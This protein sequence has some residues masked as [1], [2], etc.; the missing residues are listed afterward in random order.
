MLDDDDVRRVAL[1]FP[2]TTEKER[3]SHPTFDVA[4]KM[5]VTVP[6]DQTS[7]AVRCPRLDREELIAAEPHKFWTP[8]HEAA[9]AWVRV[10]LDELEDVRELRDIL[11]DSWRQA[12]PS[13]LIE[14][15]GS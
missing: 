2:E 15:E 7:F 9:S 3:W 12:A 11:L 14:L 6:D 1:S 5:F 8:A 4:G 10:R 13:R